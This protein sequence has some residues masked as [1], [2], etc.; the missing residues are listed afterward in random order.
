MDEL[1]QT[2]NRVTLAIS[3]INRSRGGKYAVMQALPGAANVWY[4]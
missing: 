4:I 2:K 3:A 1:E